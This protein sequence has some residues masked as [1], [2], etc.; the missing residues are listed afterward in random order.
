MKNITMTRIARP[1]TVQHDR[2]DRVVD[3]RGRA[4]HRHRVGEERAHLRVQVDTVVGCR[5]G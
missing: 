5:R 3:G 2:V 4:R 1:P